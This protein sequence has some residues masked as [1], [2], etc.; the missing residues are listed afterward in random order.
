MKNVVLRWLSGVV[1]RTEKDASCR[2]GRAV[3]GVRSVGA[4]L[5]VTSVV[6]S[7]ACLVLMAVHVGFEYNAAT[8]HLIHAAIRGIQLVFVAQAVFD[9]SLRRTCGSAPM[10]GFGTAISLVMLSTV[11][12]IVTSP[13]HISWLGVINRI[14]YGHWYTYSIMGAYAVVQVCRGLMA[15]AGRRTNPALLL[16]LSFLFFITAGWLALMM[17]RCTYHG[18]GAVDALFVATSAVC[19]TG[20]STVDIAAT[21]TPLGQ[22]VLAALFQIGALGVITFTSFFAVFFTGRQSIYSQMLVRDMVYSRSLNT[23]VPTLLYILAFTV[24]VELAGAAVLYAV[25]P[26]QLAP[27]T[28]HRVGVAVFQSMSAFCNVG[29]CNIPDGMS[30]TV[31]MRGDQLVYLTM[32]ALVFAGGVGF[33]ILVN[34]KDIAAQYHRRLVRRI[35]RRPRCAEKT[36]I[37]DLNTRVALYTTLVLLAF[38][39]LAFF[40]LESGNTMRGMSLWQRAVQSLFNAV[41]PR[42]GGYATVNPADF[43]NVT[44]LLVLVQMWIGGGS[45]SMAGGIKVNTLGAV[46]MNLRA[47]VEQ[48][49][50]TTAFGLNIATSSVRRANAVVVL[51]II[52]C[53]VFT[54]SLLLLEPAM[55]AKAVIFESVSATFSVGSSL[56]ITPYLSVPSKVLLC[57][58]MF[59]GRVGLLSLLTGMLT[60]R[61][62]VSAHLPTEDI[63]IN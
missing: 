15:A 61:R 9:L 33:P 46:V 12:P 40:V 29:F 28:M 3:E 59:V 14:I 51:S 41:I 1:A 47:V 45:Q 48:R 34:F 31:L 24:C 16:A 37:F 57:V 36:H 53:L 55:S 30:N 20:L 23:L 58:A 27:D 52:A 62:D 17:P 2:V 8:R 56:G 35:L 5:G 60:A 4:W 32:S 43:L 21:F 22:I 44:L 54:V 6:A 11:I 39:T 38:G 26:V 10:R 63:I 7:V 42:S 13:L 18:I 19:I 49:S 25:M 50:G